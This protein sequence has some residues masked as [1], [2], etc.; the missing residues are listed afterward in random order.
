MMIRSEN[1]YHLPLVHLQ[2]Q[3]RLLLYKGKHIRDAPQRNVTH[4]VSRPV[5]ITSFTCSLTI[6]CA[7]MV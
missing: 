6:K 1:R 4:V 5:A 7:Y 2:R 3:S